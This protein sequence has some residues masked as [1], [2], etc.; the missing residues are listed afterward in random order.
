MGLSDG[1]LVF[2]RESAEDLFPADPVLGEVH[3]LRRPG[4]S[5]GR[6]EL[7]ESPV[8]PGGVAV[9]QVLGR[10]PSQMVLMDDQRSVEELP[11][12]GTDDPSLAPV[13]VFTGTR[14]EHRDGHTVLT[15]GPAAGG[16]RAA[17][18][19]LPAAGRKQPVRYGGRA[20]R[21][22]VLARHDHI[23]G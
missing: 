19:C 11:A 17:G 22:R 13:V 23:F 4:V 10:H 12:Q 3:W 14:R 18:R 5:L 6:R 7:A 9:Q 20:W 1:D 2:V 15:E 21:G 16:R 8:R